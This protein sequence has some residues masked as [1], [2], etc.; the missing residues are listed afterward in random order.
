MPLYHQII[1]A[2][3]KY[4]KEGLV[5]LF[6]K[7]TKTILDNGGVVR[8]IEHH[9]IRPL[10]ERARRKYAATDGTRHFW[11]ARYISSTFDASPKALVEVER[12]LRNEEGVLRVFTTKQEV[13]ADRV[14]GGNYKNI[15]RTTVGGVGGPSVPVVNEAAAA[16]NP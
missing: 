13:G 8:G 9:G 2:L 3:P 4:S 16:A 7:H 5:A 6:R 10:P 1:V 11:D 14:R 15:F 12:F